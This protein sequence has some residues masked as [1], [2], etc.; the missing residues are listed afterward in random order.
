MLNAVMC[1]QDT[2]LPAR[3]DL[4]NKPCFDTVV[5]KAANAV[6]GAKQHADIPP[7]A[8]QQA[9]GVTSSDQPGGGLHVLFQH[10][11]LMRDSSSTAATQ[12]LQLSMCGLDASNAFSIA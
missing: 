10:V 6:E 5:K 9:A 3:L 4:S 11:F 8:L 7:A 1:T 12:D 2:L